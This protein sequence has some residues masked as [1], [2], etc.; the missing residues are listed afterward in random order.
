MQKVY[1]LLRNNQQSGPY[2]LDELLQLQ[3]KP[4]D[5][6]WVNGRSAAWQYPGEI[7]ALQPYMPITPHSDLPYQPIA[8]AAMERQQAQ[9]TKSTETIQ[10]QKKVFVSMPRAASRPS[11]IENVQPKQIDSEQP[12]NEVPNHYH[13]SENFRD[14]SVASPAGTLQVE[15]DSFRNWNQNNSKKKKSFRAKDLAATLVLGVLIAGGYY[16]LSK[17]SIVPAGQVSKTVVAP[18]SVQAPEE[19]NNTDSMISKSQFPE[20][21]KNLIPEEKETIKNDLKIKANKN[22]AVLSQPIVKG[23]DEIPIEKSHESG[24]NHSSQVIPPGTQE[25]NTTAVVKKKKIG[26]VIK[27]IFST[28]KKSEEPK[29][30]SVVLEEP[31]PATDRKAARRED[32]PTSSNTTQV[33]EKP[34]ANDDMEEKSITLADY[35]DITS[36]AP[37]NWMMGISGLKITLRNRSNVVI[38]T[39]AVNVLYYDANNK[40]L[41]RKMVYF[42]HV[43]AKGKLTQPA[44]DHKFADH[45]EIKLNAA[46]AK[47]DRYARD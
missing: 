18:V 39:A 31:R 14:A 24:R 25:S 33:P 17:P 19:K 1:L 32:P 38:Q 12:L 16:I 26:Q 45:V 10:E 29:N 8:T 6:I 44:P 23:N 30:T 2:E 20:Q 4:F 34:A 47:E 28:K 5:L 36:N 37:D 15:E 35:I 13:R 22:H 27:N 46:S 43:P 3:L 41:D 9:V 7:Q 21:K 11:P 42:S 40:L